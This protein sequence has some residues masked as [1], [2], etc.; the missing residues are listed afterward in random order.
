MPKAIDHVDPELFQWAAGKQ[1]EKLQAI[2]DHG[3]LVAASKALGVD[4]SMI[5]RAL[6]RVKQKAALSGYSPEHNM[7]RTVPAGYVVKGVSTAVG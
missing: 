7:T 2:I 3:S 1:A 4:S 5:S 6:T